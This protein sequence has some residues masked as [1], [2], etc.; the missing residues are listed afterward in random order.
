MKIMKTGAARAVITAIL[1]VA[2][3]LALMIGATAVAQPDDQLRR[4]FENSPPIA[5][6]LEYGTFKAVPITGTFSAS[7]PD[8]DELTFEITAAPKKGD[9]AP[10]GASSFVYT[11]AENAR[12]K[13]SFEYVAVD[14]AG[15]A[16]APATVSI[17]IRKR[18]AKT[19]Y[20]DMD[21]SSAQYAALVLAEEGIFTGEKLGEAWFFHPEREV[22]RGEFLA[23]CMQLNGGEVIKGVTRTGFYD[24]DAI[25]A[26]VKPYIS[27]GLVAG[28][29]NGYRNDEGKL[30]FSPQNPITFFEAAVVLDNL[31]NITSVTEAGV[32]E[33]GV[34]PAWAAA[35]SANLTACKILPAGV[36]EYSDGTV[37]RAEAAEML[38]AA[39]ALLD[40]RDGGRSLLSLISG[41]R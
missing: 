10:D 14:T 31:L 40:A 5:E 21:G 11:P 17:T 25:P 28:V 4:I 30:V 12:G 35:A 7:D 38:T 15:N 8:G 19:S 36:S 3:F 1:A 2:S 13:D 18:A 20:A 27:T 6:N 34:V 22:T 23:M 32:S 26:W 29:I 16:S 33:S 24:D 39:A 9:A 37:T 41:K